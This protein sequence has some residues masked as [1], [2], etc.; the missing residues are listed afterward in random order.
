MLNHPMLKFIEAKCLAH[1]CLFTFRHK[2]TDWEI[3]W[4]EFPKNEKK[5]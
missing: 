4:V 5:N 3:K 2:F 1:A